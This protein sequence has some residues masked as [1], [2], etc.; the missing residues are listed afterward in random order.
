MR[1]ILRGFAPIFALLL[2]AGAANA[3]PSAGDP[4]PRDLERVRKKVENLR[5][6]QLTEELDLSEAASSRL[7]PVMREADQDR[8]RIEAQNRD[9]VRELNQE[10]RQET[11]DQG[12]IDRIL[13][14][15]VKNRG[16]ITQVEERHI[17]KVRDILSAEDTARYI[18]FTIRFQREIRERIEALGRERGAG[19]PGLDLDDVPG[20][21]S[22]GK[23]R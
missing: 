18:L 9:L 11:V 8:L 20:R 21:G 10:L 2:T 6:W 22:G 19:G 7:F 12:K 17:R 1:A 16:E 13:D 15:L 23:G 14:R 4:S 5:V 3:A